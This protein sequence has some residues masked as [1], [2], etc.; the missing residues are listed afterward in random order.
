MFRTLVDFVGA[1]M[2]LTLR[3][4]CRRE[5]LDDYAHHPTEVNV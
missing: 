4:G 1:T 2:F 5:G 3:R